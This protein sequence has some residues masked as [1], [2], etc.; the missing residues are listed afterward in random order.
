MNTP[1]P[2]ERADRLLRRWL[3]DGVLGASI[4]GD[5][6]QEYS[7]RIEAGMAP[8]V[9]RW[10]WRA[11]L[12]LSSRYAAI[13]LR[14]KVLNWTSRKP[15]GGEIVNTLMA[16]L[17]LGFRMLVKT[18]M[19]SLVAIVT[20]AM[21]VALTTHT[22][23]SVWGTIGRGL[24]VPGEDRLMAVSGIRPDLGL[25]GMDMSIHE[26]EDLRDQQTS[27]ESLEA[28]YQG[29]V[30]LGGDEGPPERFDGGFVSAAA[31]SSLGVP[32]LLG[33]TFREG[34][35]RSDAPLVVVLGHDLWQGR[36]AGDADVLG[37]F[38][39]VNG[40]TA[41][42]IGVMPAGFA[43]PFTEKIWA[44]HRIDAAGLDWGRGQD[45]DVFGRL[46]EGV[47]VAAG[48]A[49]LQAMA[50]RQ[51]ELHP[52]TNAQV[53]L[54]LEPFEQRYMPPEIRAVL[55]TMLA[56]TFGVLLIAC[57]NVA[58]LLLARAALRTK[59]V[60]V[61]TALGASRF[62]V[63][64]QMMVE[65]LVL[66]SIGG[67]LGLCVAVWGLG[68]YD[69]AIAGIPKPYWIDL[70]VDVPMLLFTVGVTAVAAVAAGIL[71]ALRASGVEIGSVLKDENRGSSSLRLG[72]FSYSLVVT[73]IAVSASLLV[74]AGFMVKSVVNLRNI[75][76]GFETENVLTGR[77]GLF[78]ADYPTPESRRE[79][80]NLLKERLAAQPTVL[81][82]AVGA[83]LPGLGT[84]QYY[85]AVEGE[86][87]TTDADHPLAYTTTI[88]EDYFA[89]F[90]VPLLHGRD[91]SPLDRSGEGQEVA[92]VNESFAA[93][94]FSNQSAL[95]ARIRLGVTNSPLPWHT[96]VGVVPDTY[97]GG[98]VGGIGDDQV[99]PERIY[100]P[101]GT[102]NAQFVS[103]AL[104][105]QGPP[106]AM[107]ATVR[108]T[109]TDLDANLPVYELQPLDQA[110]DRAT[111]AFD[112]FGAIFTIVGVVALFLAAVG[113]YGVIAFSVAQRRQEM[114]V[115]MALGADRGSIMGLVLKRG[116]WQLGLGMGIGLLV[117]A[118]LARPLR[119]VL[120]GVEISDP[121]VYVLIALTMGLAGFAA[122]WIPARAA[123]RTQPVIAMRPR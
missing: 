83:G 53:S 112:L 86:S 18:P 51:G 2:P 6:H 81:E 78:E 24:P 62:A 104:R 9:N 32:P 76:L 84:G 67:A 10:Y 91:F 55:W 117:G 8:G 40:E 42:V 41:E 27:F 33:R 74:A 35:D 93:R 23:S 94:H 101:L 12:G 56:G 50:V 73:E 58:N 87:Y 20:V 69:N 1:R 97:V 123:T 98:G 102:L 44:P 52:E 34:E 90:G 3:P 68:V 72:R 45:V 99:S 85:L 109:V 43:F 49:E 106:A 110:I 122:L 7:E 16:D 111:W 31:L 37:R 14:D 71:P 118:A 79:F 64:R 26:F 82:A 115:R 29:T 88:T 70:R 54:N 89:T 48:R 11:A 60:A 92:I 75:D 114:G 108:G 100:L 46:R 38:I 13:R 63:V 121:I 96:I 5:L 28:Y 120:Y 47:S 36:F 80:F 103:F 25:T 30:N 119:F 107:A 15:F 77:I 22:F 113:L 95:G 57:V 61:R 39:R 4:V 19:L 116:G 21:G 105:T 59:E 66:V 65:S 17:R